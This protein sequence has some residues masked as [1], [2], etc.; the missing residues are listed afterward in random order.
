MRDTRQHKHEGALFKSY[1]KFQDGDS[2]AL[3]RARGPLLSVAPSVISGAPL[4]PS[5]PASLPGCLHSLSPRDLPSPNRPHD[6]DL[7]MSTV[8]AS[9]KEG[10]IRLSGFTNNESPGLRSMKITRNGVHPGR[11][12]SRAGQRPRNQSCPACGRGSQA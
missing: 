2:G 9:P 7:R 3:N 11:S 1:R 4:K 12:S 5:L 8:K 6:F 10:Q